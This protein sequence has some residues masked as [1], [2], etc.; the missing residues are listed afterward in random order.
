MAGRLNWG[1]VFIIIGLVALG[2]TTGRLPYDVII[3]LADLWPVLLVAVGIQMIF[4][5]SKAPQFAYLSS[6][7][8]IL[9]AAYAISPYWDSIKDRDTERE[10]GRLEKVLEEDISA[11]EVRAD[12]DNR[13]F[14][15][16]DY[17]GVGTEFKFDR[18]IISP[19][20][21]FQA[22]ESLGIVNL[23]H[24]GN[25]WTRFLKSRDLPQWK[26]SLSQ[27]YP[28]DL[29]LKS[30]KGYCYLRMADLDINILDLEC[31]NCYDVVLQ[32]G[33]KFPSEPILLDLRRSKLRLDILKGTYVIIREGV[34][35]PFYLTEDL[36]FL[37]SGN[38]LISDSLMN[39]DSTLIVEIKSGLKEFIV[40]RY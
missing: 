36:G 35:L 20:M 8:I 18:E 34:A 4:S 16:T 19:R 39:P 29:Y 23:S 1:L 11:I 32:F 15:L 13:D 40:N 33:D 25:R 6:I 28:L 22:D 21:S 12:F 3:S 9:T 24:Q 30:K 14:I 7:L 27:D 17:N 31:E 37:E 5:R 26:L 2:C 38:D 10:S